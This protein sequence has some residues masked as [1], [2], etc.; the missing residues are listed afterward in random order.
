MNKTILQVPIS[1][2]LKDKAEEASAKQG[3]SSLQESVRVFLAKLATNRLEITIQEPIKLSESSERRYLK[4]TLDFEKNKNT[5]SAK[6]VDELMTKLNA[7]K[8]S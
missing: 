6:T 5:R 8:I 3:F 1:K 4:Q 7:N 2:E